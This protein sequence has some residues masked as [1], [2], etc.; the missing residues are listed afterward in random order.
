MCG[1]NLQIIEKS[2]ENIM[3]D[4][5]KLSI[6]SSSC[7]FLNQ[8]FYQCF[9]VVSVVLIISE[10]ISR[11]FRLMIRL[12]DNSCVC[13]SCYRLFLCLVMGMCQMWLSV[14]CN[15]ENIVVVLMISVIIEMFVVIMFL[16]GWFIDFSKFWM[17]NVFLVLMMLWI[18]LMIL[19]CV[20]LWLNSML[21]IVMV[22]IS[23][24]VIEKMVQQVMVVFMLGVKLLI[25]VLIVVIVICQVCWVCVLFLI[26]LILVVGFRQFEGVGF[27]LVLM[28]LI[29]VGVFVGS[30]VLVLVLVVVVL[31]WVDFLCQVVISGMVS[32]ISCKV[33]FSFCGSVL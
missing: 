16:C 11:K 25:Q 4:S 27:S 5:M 18:W 6:C 13:V 22:I 30:G 24:G 1:M 19:F 17:V 3:K 2:V 23:M 29:C 20:V 15:F 32:V 8:L 21:V 12:K 7:Y 14:F 26:I 33:C 31:V 9:S 28:M 10:M